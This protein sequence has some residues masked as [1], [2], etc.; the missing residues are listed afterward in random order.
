MVTGVKILSVWKI[1]FTF[2]HVLVLIN[3]RMIR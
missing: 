3:Y 2:G 1:V